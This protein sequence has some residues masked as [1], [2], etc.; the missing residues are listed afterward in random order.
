MRCVSPTCS[1]DRNRTVKRLALRPGVTSCSSCD[2]RRLRPQGAS[3]YW[4]R[5]DLCG[6]DPRPRAGVRPSGCAFGGGWRKPMRL[7]T[8]PKWMTSGTALRRLRRGLT[9]WR[10]LR[11]HGRDEGRPFHR[12][13]QARENSR[14][15]PSLR[16]DLSDKE[17]LMKFNGR[18]VLITGGS[19]G[20]GLAFARRFLDLGAVVIV[21]GRRQEAG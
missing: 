8:A 17:N 15:R 4:R 12:S 3:P 9:T 14:Q 6:L 19:N 11:K 20:I 13:L 5:A 21:T 18:T 16:L 7:C 10:A 2:A 1:N